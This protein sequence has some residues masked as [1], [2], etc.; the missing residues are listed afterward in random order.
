MDEDGLDPGADLRDD[1]GPVERLHGA[2]A[3]D[4]PLGRPEE[5]PEEDGAK[6][7]ELE[8]NAVALFARQQHPGAADA[9]AG[10]Q[11][12]QRLIIAR[13]NE[14]ASGVIGDPLGHAARGQDL[15]FAA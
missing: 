9:L 5:N 3:I 4:V 15:G 10:R 11:K 2:I 1:D 7:P 14:R 8:K 12:R 6:K 13:G